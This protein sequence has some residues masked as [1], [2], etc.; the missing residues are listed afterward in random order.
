MNSP[1]VHESSVQLADV[2]LSG[3]V[4]ASDA[5]RARWMI[6]HLFGRAAEAGEMARAETFVSKYGAAAGENPEAKAWAAFAR[7]L[8]A[9]NEFL[10]IE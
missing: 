9:S 10:Y 4:G 7:A 3:T 8:F 1:L 5:E 6:R 2:M